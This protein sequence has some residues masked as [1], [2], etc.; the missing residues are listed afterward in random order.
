MADVNKVYTDSEIKQM[1]Q[2]EA[3]GQNMDYSYELANHP[4]KFS[5]IYTTP[6]TQ[7]PCQMCMNEE[8]AASGNSYACTTICN[9]CRFNLKDKMYCP[10]CGRKL[11]V[12]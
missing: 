7:E 10:Y 8:C 4:E 3:D 12:H 9:L 2:E 11:H 1:M 5:V 6:P